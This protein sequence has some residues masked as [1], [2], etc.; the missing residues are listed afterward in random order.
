MDST[1]QPLD[2]FAVV[3]VHVGPRAVFIGDLC[4]YARERG[5]IKSG[6]PLEHALQGIATLL[7][8]IEDV[9]EDVGCRILDPARKSRDQ[10]CERGFGF[11]HWALPSVLQ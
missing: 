11:V 7:G 9:A 5:E 6:F 8:V 3:P 2:S 1:Q 10:E 4:G